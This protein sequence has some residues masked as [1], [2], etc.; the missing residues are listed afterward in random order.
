M[1]KDRFIALRKDNGFTQATF[2]KALGVSPGYIGDI[3][4]G[5]RFVSLKLAMRMEG[6][7]KLPIVAEFV[8]SKTKV[9]A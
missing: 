8:A 6:E 3:E 4:R 7:L 5:H 2:A 9:A 1:D